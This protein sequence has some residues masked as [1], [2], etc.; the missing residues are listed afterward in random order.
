[1]KFFQNTSRSYGSTQWIAS[2]M[3]EEEDSDEEDESGL[4]S[5]GSVFSVRTIG[6]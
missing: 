6:T 2:H 3:A 1:M 4:Y 5:S